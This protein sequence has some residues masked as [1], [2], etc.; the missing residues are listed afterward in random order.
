[1][2]KVVFV[3]CGNGVG[4]EELEAQCEG[5]PNVRFLDLQPKEELGTLL[6][7]ADI[8]L[9]P[10][11]PGAADLC[12]P[13]K[14]TNILASGRPVVATCEERSE[15]GR[16][17]RDRGLIVPHG[18][19]QAFVDAVLNLAQDEELRV[20]LGDN[21]RAYAEQHLSRDQILTAF[22]AEACNGAGHPKRAG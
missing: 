12:M 16:A 6:E 21:A 7:A 13:S 19:E 18:D 2:T 10:Q 17:V 5:L 3:F 20:R 9:L 1:M 8:H 14:L 22:Q 4:R 11:H 15:V